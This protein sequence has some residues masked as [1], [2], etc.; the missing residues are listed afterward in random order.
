MLF[1]LADDENSYV[2]GILTS[3]N[4]FDGTISTQT[5]HYYVEPAGKYSNDLDGRGIHTIVYRLSDVKMHQR[6]Q[7]QLNSAG[8]AED[9]ADK[10]QCASGRLHAKLMKA[11]GSGGTSDTVVIS[12]SNKKNKNDKKQLKSTKKNYF[13]DSKKD[14]SDI[15]NYY[16]TV[17]MGDSRLRLSRKRKKRWLTDEVSVEVCFY[18]KV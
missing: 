13:I 14:K 5:D 7:Q 15:Y 9:D 11:A 18:R 17:L 2:H 4:L 10:Y 12:S 1:P 6:Q 16:K 3:D 8:G